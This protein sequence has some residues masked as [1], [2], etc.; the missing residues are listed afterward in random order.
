MTFSWLKQ[1][2]L[3]FFKL[4]RCYTPGYQAAYN[5]LVT[6]VEAPVALGRLSVRYGLFTQPGRNDEPP[7]LVKDALP[8]AA[9]A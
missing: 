2:L 8:V 5:T 7:N 4:I 9:P 3:W 6:A 1:C